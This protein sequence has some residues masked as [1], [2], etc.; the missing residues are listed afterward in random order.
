M[1]TFIFFCSILKPSVLKLIVLF[2]S[3]IYKPAFFSCCRAEKALE[4]IGCP[5]RLTAKPQHSCCCWIHRS[6]NFLFESG[7]FLMPDIRNL[8]DLLEQLVQLLW[9]FKISWIQMDPNPKDDGPTLDPHT[10]LQAVVVVVVDAC[11]LS[12]CG[13]LLLLRQSPR[14]FNVSLSAG[15]RLAAAVSSP[16]A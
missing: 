3:H 16:Q 11:L 2:M 9:H 4:Q 7:R 6:G 14:S 13:S 10:S 5:Q 15:T 8:P 1:M 12:L